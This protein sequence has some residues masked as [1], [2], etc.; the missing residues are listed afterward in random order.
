MA[1]PKRQID[2][3]IGGETSPSSSNEYFDDHNPIDDS[4][5]ARAAKATSED[6]DRAVQVAHGAFADYRQTVAKDREGWLIRAAQLLEEQSDDFADILIDEIGSPVSKARFEIV[7]SVSILRAAAGSAR[8]ATGKTMPSDVP[9]R[10]SLSVRAPLG[11]VAAITPFNV[12]LSKGVRLTASALALGNTVVQMPS[13]EAPVMALRLAQLYADAGIPAGAF[14]VVTGLGHEIGDSLTGHPLVRVVTFTGSCPVG[15]HIQNICAQQNKKLTLELGGKSPLVVMQDADLDK[16]VAGAVQSMFAYQGQI[17]MAASRMFV[18]RPVFDQFMEQFI[19]AAQS[20][21]RGDLRDTSTVIGPIINRRQ[22]DRIKH[23]IDDAAAKGANI[24]TGGEWEEHRCQPTILTGVTP[25]M[26]V[27]AEETFG[28]VTSVYAVDDLDD[29]ISKA[30][31]SVF[32]LSASIYTSNLDAAMIFA[33]EVHSGMVHINAPTVYAEPHV[34]FGG[35]GESGFGR[36]GTEV[37][38]DL[39]TEWKWITVQ[40]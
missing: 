6:M 33:N 15:K 30:N 22:R 18:E 27:Y 8:M 12:P 23:H 36:E 2:L 1:D 26:A 32:G 21:G 19:A 35:V 31:D 40:Q 14:N 17:C 4:L 20:L 3:W 16:A 10:F 28:P 38:I 11:V 5:Y 39:M 37:D 24:V 34:P 25:E 9:G 7:Q 29:A 13:E